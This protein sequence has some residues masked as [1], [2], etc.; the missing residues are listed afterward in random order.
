MRGLVA[1][2]RVPASAGPCGSCSALR[3]INLE[4]LL[5]S[6]GVAEMCRSRSNRSNP[7]VNPVFVIGCMG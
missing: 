1:H 3:R 2:P 6:R 7:V 5:A 4:A